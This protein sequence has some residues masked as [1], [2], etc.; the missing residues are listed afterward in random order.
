MP[1]GFN[2]Q[3]DRLRRGASGFGSSGDAL[4]QAGTTLGSALDAQGQC[5]GNDESGQSFA[6]DYVPNSQKVR[7]AFGSLAEALQA[8]KTALEESANSYE[9]VEDQ[10]T[11]GY[12]A[13][14]G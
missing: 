13:M 4:S 2:V 14:E 8:I 5:W 12:R 10:S 6:K 11:D 7:D 3:T 1:D 9:N